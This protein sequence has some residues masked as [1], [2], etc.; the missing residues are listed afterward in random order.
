MG[1]KFDVWSFE[2]DYNKKMK[3]VID[4]LK[5]KKLLRKSQGAQIVNLKEF[6]LGVSL[7]EK[8]DGASLYSTRD[9]AAAIDRQ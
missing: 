6:N 3:K 2:S 4:D 5:T 1:I 7:I 8:S 9:L